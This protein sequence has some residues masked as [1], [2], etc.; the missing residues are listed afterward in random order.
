MPRANWIWKETA[1]IVGVITIVISLVFVGVQIRDGNREARA[2]TM[3]SALGVEMDMVA[4]FIENVAVWD[5]VLTNAPLAEGEETRVALLLFNLLMTD[6]EN[7]FHQFNAGYLD[8]SIWEARKSTLPEFAALPL[9]P[10][11]RETAGARSRSANF[12]D[13]MD[14]FARE[15]A[16][17]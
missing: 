16:A 2:A 9:Y 7:R 13:L 15:A 5:K 14:D 6:T 1:E 8:V 4:G 3:V 17:Q 12:L 11:W 10:I